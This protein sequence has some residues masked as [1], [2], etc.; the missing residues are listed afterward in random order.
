MINEPGQ[1]LKYWNRAQ[2][3]KEVQNGDDDDHDYGCD[4]GDD[5]SDDEDD[6]NEHENWEDTENNGRKISIFV[7]LLFE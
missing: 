1:I 7:I 6:D 4:D 5:D 2:P 3:I